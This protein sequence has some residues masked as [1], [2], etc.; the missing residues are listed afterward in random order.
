M[1]E[2]ENFVK[3]IKEKFAE[4]EIQMARF[5]H[6]TDLLSYIML[7][8]KIRENDKIV[9]KPTNVLELSYLKLCAKKFNDSENLFE[10]IFLFF[11]GYDLREYKNTWRLNLNNLDKDITSKCSYCKI[12]SKTCPFKL[13]AYIKK[14]IEDN[15]FDSKKVFDLLGNKAQKEYTKDP[16]A[17]EF[18]VNNVNEY[19]K[20]SMDIVA[21]KMMLD[22]DAVKLIKEENGIVYYKYLDF[23]VKNNSLFNNINEYFKKGKGIEG[24]FS[25]ANINFSNSNSY[26]FDK[27]PVEL[28]VY[29][30]YLSDRSNVNEQDAI[31]SILEKRNF[32]ESEFRI[33]YYNQ[34]VHAVEELECSENEKKEIIEILTYIRNYYFNEDLPYIHFNIALYTKNNIISD[35]VINIINKFAR[36]YGYITNKGTLWVDT[37]MLVKRTKDSTDMIMQVEKMYTDNDI[38]IFENL[39]KIKTL[40]EYR[41]DAL[42]TSI[43]K[44]NMRNKKSITIIVENED[45]FKELT[46]KHPMLES[47]IMNKKIRIDGY[48]FT[49]IKDRIMQKL[50]GILKI[51]KEFE[52]ALENYIKNTYNSDTMNEYVYMENLY[53]QI[54]FNKFKILNVNNSFNKE[55]APKEVET[56]EVEEILADI[57][58]LVGLTDVKESINEFIK[59]LDYSRKIN[60]EGFAN[61]NMIFKGNS[62]TGKTTVARLLAELFYKLGFIRENKIIEV[63]SK[64][65]I[66]SHLGETAPKTQA[67]IE[68]ALDG[69]L[70]IDEAYTIM[71][72][73]GGGTSNYP[74]ECMATIYKAMELYKDRLVVIFAGYTN[75]MN[76][77]INSN[78]GLMSRIGYEL[79]FPDFSK[80]ELMQIFND[81]A[82][83]NE[84]TLEDGVSEK[85][86]KI[87]QKNKI[88]RNFGNARFVINLFDKLV[89]THASKCTDDNLL[90]TIT[91]K[92]IEFYE[93]TKKD[94][95]RSVD[96]ILKELN[97]LIGLKT[98]KETITGFVSVIE[99]DKK[100]ERIPDFNMH[101]IFKGNAGTGKTTVARLI[102][103]VYYNLGYI[104]RNKFV[105]VQSQDL[106]GEF[107][108]Q[109]GPKTQAVIESALDGVLFIDEA[110]SIMEH[111]G[112]NAS[113][114]AECVATLLKAMEDYQ[115]R[116]IIIFAGYTDEMK[117][118]RDLN[119]GLK[120]RVGYEIDFE[121]YSLEE[122]MDI[123]HKKVTDKG[124]RSSKGAD[125]KVQDILKNAKEVENF[126]NG[127]FVENMVQ[128]IIIEHAVQTRN[129]DDMDRL[130]TFEEEDVKN[131]KAEESRKRIGF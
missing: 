68:A 100:L 7:T 4:N 123:Y 13:S 65:L 3:Y 49:K 66:G 44:F 112:T 25:L 106:I 48:E 72:S 22:S 93:E 99:L 28:A 18:I 75:E 43:E 71:S 79:E 125:Q 47:T 26:L 86:E 9:E 128:K 122:L 10:K 29:I 14:C 127:R 37:E 2:T 98:V 81:E 101:M 126:G 91:N 23:N 76:D 94:K 97:S 109:T 116:L 61:L 17:I 36:T 82:N 31:K 24:E 67:T 6:E 88:G 8:E 104:K 119:P 56:R 39:E 115:G 41:V 80:T 34:Y 95:E 55:D 73:K 90:K 120:S 62:G 57:N 85:I 83:G 53:N 92:D 30:K 103:E 20:N 114:S 111:S 16:F 11:I 38:V 78:Q 102:A 107:L 35:K 131:I 58:G 50:D 59:Y 19:I 12:D 27:S 121:D 45:I 124:F 117:K 1:D 63:T 51:N 15:K 74:A 64:D 69:V 70:F 42:F 110:Y 118:F 84:F 130:L 21:A 54:I 46:Q 96:D 105:E 129:V 87:I 40:N 32:K 5:I 77:F 113:Y 89:L 52:D 33:A 60:T 108:G